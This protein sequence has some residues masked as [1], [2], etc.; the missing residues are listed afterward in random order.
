[1]FPVYKNIFAYNGYKINSFT[2]QTDNF[3]PLKLLYSNDSYKTNHITEQFFDISIFNL[4]DLSIGNSVT[5][6]GENAFYECIRLTS[7]SFG[8]SLTSIGFAAFT[9]CD[10]LTSVTSPSSVDI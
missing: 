2:N 4:N 8:N 9:S 10:N 5:S 1:M 3:N 7:V 6:I